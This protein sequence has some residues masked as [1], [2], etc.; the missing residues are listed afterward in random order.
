MSSTDSSSRRQF[1]KIGLGA[2]VGGVVA[3][4][5]E[6]PY[7]TNLDNQKDQKIA[8]LEAQLSSL[9]PQVNQVASLQSQVSTLT[10]Q[11][12]GLQSELDTMTG[13]LCLGL[14]EQVELEA[15]VET[16]IPSDSNG[17][18]A[19]EAGVIYFIDGQLTS[20]YGTGGIMYMKGPFELSGQQGPITVD[21]ITYSQGTPVQAVSAGTHYQ[22]AMSMRYFWKWGLAALQSYA[23]SAYGGNFETLSADNQAQVL[24]DTWANKPAS[25]NGIV[26]S[27]FAW[28][29]FFM[30]WSGFLTDPLYGGN[31]NMVG[32]ALLGFNGTNQ[33]N[34]YGEGHTPL[35]L[36]LSPTPIPLKAASLAQFQQQTP[37]L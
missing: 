13:F 24:A 1:L 37:I 8:S 3:S 18:G 26:P 14:N 20:G 17:P 6:V 11:S 4:V 21:G 29:L 27:D 22:Y 9:Q 30:T 23:N 12:K 10:T 5:A 16:I 2:A 7:F 36:A 28:E 32:W 31:R 25:F 33:G 35:E 34:F 19:K 15:I